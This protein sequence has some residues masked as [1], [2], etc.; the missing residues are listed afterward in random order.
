MSLLIN[1]QSGSTYDQLTVIT[2]KIPTAE[3]LLKVEAT[4]FEC[5]STEY[6]VHAKYLTQLRDSSGVDSSML[7]AFPALTSNCRCCERYFC[8][9][10]TLTY[11]YRLICCYTVCAR[12]MEGKKKIWLSSCLHRCKLLKDDSVSAYHAT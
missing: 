4:L 5:S 11:W 3:I 6:P 9:H 12:L 2:A 7:S 10:D 8:I 1:I